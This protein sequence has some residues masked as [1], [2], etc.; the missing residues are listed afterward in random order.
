MTRKLRLGVLVS[1]GGRTMLNIADC[2][3]RGDLPASVAVVI[4]SCN[5]AAAVHRAR[6]RG[7]DVRV[8][9]QKNFTDEKEMH[10][11]ITSLLLEHLVDL[12][13]LSGYMRWYRVDSS[14]E[15]RVMN[16]HPALLPDFGGQGM[17]GRHVHRAVLDSNATVSGCTI[18]FVDDQYDH[19]PIILQRTCPVLPGDDV[20]HLAGRV[21]EQEC[22]AY[23][24]AIRLFAAD[25]LSVEGGVVNILSNSS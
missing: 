5:E 21:F 2:I 10:D 24:E 20:D 8:A 16:V 6:D 3:D 13:C 14:F 23:P 4:S 7:F 19:G 15:Q 17:Y 22:L 18:H 11:A 25:R 12:V 9:L 1:G